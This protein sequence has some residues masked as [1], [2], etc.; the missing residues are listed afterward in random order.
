ML[1][2][3]NNAKTRNK[4]QSMNNLVSTDRIEVSQFNLSLFNSDMQNN[5]NKK[6][7][8]EEVNPKTIDVTEY[9]YHK[10]LQFSDKMEKKKQ[11]CKKRIYIL[12]LNRY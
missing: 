8:K 2:S 12:V 4:K 7:K 6:K 1:V 9:D 10:L 5:I 3:I 11:I